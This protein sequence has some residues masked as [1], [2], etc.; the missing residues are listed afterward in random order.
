MSEVIAQLRALYGGEALCTRGIVHVV[1]VARAA[2]GLL[3]PLRIGEG[4]PHSPT[5][6]F[7]LNL[8]RARADAILTSGEN[9]RC[10]AG[11]SMALQGPWAPALSAYRREVLGKPDL[12]VCALLTRSGEL[13]LEHPLWRDGTRKLV[14]TVPERASSLQRELGTRAEVLGVDDLDAAKACTLLQSG[15]AQLV[16]IE[17][18]PTLAR[19]L[20]EPTARVDE[21]LLTEWL[22]YDASAAVATALPADALLFAHRTCRGESTRSEHGH[23]FRFSRWT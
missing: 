8:C 16:S 7:V 11:L 9:L 14:L 15:G 5:D 10:E 19:A 21:L 13:P 17:A 18:G 3:H 6:F 12:P 2:D 4:A 22:G 1:Y 20:Y 23:T